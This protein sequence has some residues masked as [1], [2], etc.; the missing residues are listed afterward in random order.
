MEFVTKDSGERTEFPSGMVRDKS[1]GK[2][3]YTFVLTGPML[4]R[5]A[6]LLMRGAEKYDRDNWTRAEGQEELDRF[7]QSAFRH[8]VQWLRGDVDEDHA[9]AVMFNLNGAEYVKEK[10]DRAVDSPRMADQECDEE[11]WIEESDIALSSIGVSE[12]LGRLPIWKS[13]SS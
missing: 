11:R 7:R 4:D 10:M 2:I 12:S 13:R 1:D 8:L 6:K 9:A 3:D 5:W